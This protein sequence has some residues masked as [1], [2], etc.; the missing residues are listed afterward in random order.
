ML[1]LRGCSKISSTTVRLS[2]FTRVEH[3]IKHGE[4]LG[5]IR[6]I[7]Y[8]VKYDEFEENLIDE[9]EKAILKENIQL[10]KK[11]SLSPYPFTAGR[12]STP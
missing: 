12:A 3:Y 1:P 9:L 8:N 2:L 11:Y 4:G 6:K 10:P 7:F 5:H